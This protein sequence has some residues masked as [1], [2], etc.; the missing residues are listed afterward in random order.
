[1][2]NL[3]GEV[4]QSILFTYDAAGHP[5]TPKS[6]TYNVQSPDMKPAVI[7][8]THGGGAP[9]PVDR[10]TQGNVPR[11]PDPASQAAASKSSGAAPKDGGTEPAK[12]RSIWQRMFS[13]DKD[14]KEEKK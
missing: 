6:R 4:Y 1:M 5:L 2:T 10:G 7:D 9:P 3:Q 14:K 12:K 8:F 11:L 13:K